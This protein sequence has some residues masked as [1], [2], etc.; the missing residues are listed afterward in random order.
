APDPDVP[1]VPMLSSLVKRS[2]L[3]IADLFGVIGMI[4]RGLALPPGAP[5]ASLQA[6]RTAFSRMLDNPEYR[7][8]AARLKLRV[9]PTSGDELSKAIRDSINNADGALIER[10]RSLVTPK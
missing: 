7:A 2:D 9:L 1:T 10:V 5:D 8:E 6:L 3:P 4:G